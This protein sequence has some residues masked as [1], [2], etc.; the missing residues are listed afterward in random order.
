MEGLKKGG[1]H[2]GFYSNIEIKHN[3]ERYVD[4]IMCRNSNGDRYEDQ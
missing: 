1:C 2:D 4:Q 3:D